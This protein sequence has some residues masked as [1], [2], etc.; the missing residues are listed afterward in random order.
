MH[1]LPLRVGIPC[2]IV[3]LVVLI[4]AFWLEPLSHALGERGA[5]AVGPRAVASGD[6]C[7]RAIDAVQHAASLDVALARD[8]LEWLTA[9][10]EGLAAKAASVHAG[11]EI[12]ALLLDAL[13]R[14]VAEAAE[15]TW[16]HQ[17]AG[18]ANATSPDPRIVVILDDGRPESLARVHAALTERLAP[19]WSAVL[20][21]M[22]S[23]QRYDAVVWLTRAAV[24]ITAHLHPVL[25]LAPYSTPILHLTCGEEG[26]AEAD[27]QHTSGNSILRAYFSL[28]HASSTPAPDCAPNSTC[29]TAPS[30]QTREPCRTVHPRTVLAGVSRIFPGAVGAAGGYTPTWSD[31]LEPRVPLAGQRPS[32][33]CVCL[34]V[35]VCVCV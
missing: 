13:Q 9:L 12:C 15:R 2:A 31:D 11:S 21:E 32:S 19:G 8:D 4:K 6:T 30:L 28:A 27:A 35:C 29:S 20:V 16:T 24:I 1:A 26:H 5:H 22:K 23:G 33:M 17:L 25:L 14:R 34:F 18:P 3:V 10:R 7:A